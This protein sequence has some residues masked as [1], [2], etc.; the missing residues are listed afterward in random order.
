MLTD[1]A[2]WVGSTDDLLAGLITGY[3]EATQAARHELRDGFLHGACMATQAG[4]IDAA[5]LAGDWD[6]ASAPAW[7]RDRLRASKRGRAPSGTGAWTC[8][9]PLLLIQSAGSA[10]SRSTRITIT[11]NVLILEAGATPAHLLIAL[12]RLGQLDDAGRING[13]SRIREPYL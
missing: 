8:A 11:G 4:L 10:R 12:K 7:E 6:E 9:V 13:P 3:A 1:G 5:I 2:L